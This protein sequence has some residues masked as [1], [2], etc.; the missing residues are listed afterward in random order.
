[1]HPNSQ[2]ENDIRPIATTCPIYKIA[3]TCIDKF[4]TEHFNLVLDENQFGSTRGRSTTLALI[5]F[6]SMLFE[7]SDDCFNFILILF[8][9]FSK[10]FAVI[11]HNVLL[12]KFADYNF[13]THVVL[14]SLSFL[15]DRKQFVKIG[16][17][18]SDVNV[19]NAGRPTPHGTRAGP[20]NFNLLINDLPFDLP[21]IKY[22]T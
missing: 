2:A 14:W 20:N 10:A 6:S 5:K 9:D 8:I 7:A 18:F 17:L 13:P 12:K 11:D 19:I 1:M 15:Q 4:F 16:D 3:E 22:G 21:Y